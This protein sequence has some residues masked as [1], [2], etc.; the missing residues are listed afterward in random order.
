MVQSENMNRYHIAQSIW[1]LLSFFGEKGQMYEHVSKPESMLRIGNLDFC[2][3]S[4][5]RI[6]ISGEI[7]EENCKAALKSFSKEAAQQLSKIVFMTQTSV[8]KLCGTVCYREGADY[9]I[10]NRAMYRNT[11]SSFEHHMIPRL[12]EL[13]EQGVPEEF[14]LYW[15]DASM[16]N[17]YAGKISLMLF[18]LEALAKSIGKNKYQALEEILGTDLKERVFGKKSDI[19]DGSMQG[20]RNQ[21]VH[22]E[23][24]T[25]QVLYADIHKKTI[26][27]FNNNI[28]KTPHLSEDFVSPQRNSGNFRNCISVVYSQDES[29]DVIK[30][31][32]H[33]NLNTSDIPSFVQKSPYYLKPDIDI[34]AL[35]RR[36]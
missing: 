25:N 33:L 31:L 24:H 32:K 17:N 26:E 34:D 12:K 4:K 7:E 18:A 27:Y 8:E 2:S 28:L 21:L 11:G 22:G 3:I 16:V 30:M 29:F 10:L 36:Y 19:R 9:A 15:M 1:T 5:N 23:Y 6:M 14:Y 13:N 35:I 20:M